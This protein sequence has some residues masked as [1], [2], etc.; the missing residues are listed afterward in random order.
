MKCIMKGVGD[1]IFHNNIISDPAQFAY[2]LD[3]I[4]HRQKQ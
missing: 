3:R 4:F 2:L 1:A